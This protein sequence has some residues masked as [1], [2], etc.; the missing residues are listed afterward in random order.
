VTSSPGGISCN[1]GCSSDTGTFTIG[2][3][4]TLTATPASGSTFVGWSVPG[5]GGTSCT[6]TMTGDQTVTATFNAAT[7]MRT[8]T[9]TKTGS[10]S[11]TVTSS[12]AGISCGAVCTFSFTNGT[13]VTL[14][15]TP[16]AGSTF[17]GWGGGGGGNNTCDDEPTCTL[18]MDRSRSI[19]AD[20]DS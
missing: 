7:V 20:F 3:P 14:T 6:V 5:C 19:S 16:A 18:T 11:G 8:L 12:P 4:V 1:A 10:G 2:T 15:A 17:D 13:V 9:V